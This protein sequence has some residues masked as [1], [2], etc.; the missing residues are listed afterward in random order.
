MCKITG[1]QEWEGEGD[2]GHGHRERRERMSFSI[3][4]IPRTAPFNVL[5]HCLTGDIS[6]DPT[7]FPCFWNSMLKCTHTSKIPKKKNLWKALATAKWSFQLLF[8][9]L[10]GKLP[11]LAERLH[12]P[13]WTKHPSVHLGGQPVS[14]HEQHIH[15]THTIWCVKW[16]SLCWTCSLCQK[17]RKFAIP[18]LL[19][20]Y[21]S[22]RLW[23]QTVR[24]VKVKDWHQMK[25][26]LKS[27]LPKLYAHHLS[28]Y[29]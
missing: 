18:S 5:H 14:H 27:E 2:E 23:R 26:C 29:Q 11:W 20:N 9:L 10:H 1:Q 24:H 19:F 4:L 16:N 13:G 12:R 7:L 17:L 25:D 15:V 21:L 8:M 22:T 28:C 6:C 3:T